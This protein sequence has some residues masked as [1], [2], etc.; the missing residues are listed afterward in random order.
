MESFAKLT[1]DKYK[2][3]QPFQINSQNSGCKTIKAVS[4]LRMCAKV[5]DWLQ[6][7]PSRNSQIRCLIWSTAFVS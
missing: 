7:I 4:V 2:Q 5:S 1:S 6:L 3:I